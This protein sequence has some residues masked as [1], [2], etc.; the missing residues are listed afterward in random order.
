MTR[1]TILRKTLYTA[2]IGALAGGALPMHA[3]AQERGAAPVQAPAPVRFDIPAQPMPAALQAFSDQSGMQLLYRAEAVGSMMSPAVKGTLDRREALQQMLAGTGLEV[4]YSNGDVATV[5]PRTVA[6]TRENGGAAQ[7]DRGASLDGQNDLEDDRRQAP[8]TPGRRNVVIGEV[9]VTGTRI[10]GGETP[11]PVITIGAENIR[12]EG[13]TDLGEVIRSVPQNF[14]GGQNPG[15]AAGA[16]TGAAGLAN[17]N[18][19]GG[20]S[21]NLRGLGPDATLTLLNGRRMAYGGFTQT[22]DISAIPVEAVDRV[23]IVAD[24]SSAIYGSDAVGGVG[25][26]ILKRDFEGLSLGARY[27]AASDGGMVTNEYNATAG[28]NWLGGGLLATYKYSS[29][30]PIYAANRDYTDHL[31]EPTTIYPGSHVRSGLVSAYQA[32]GQLAELRIDALR[33]ERDQRF[34]YWHT[35][36]AHF[37]S[38]ILPETTTSLVAPSVEIALPNDWTLSIGGA[39]GKD[40]HIWRMFDVSTSSAQLTS[41]L[42]EC[43]CNETR[44]YELG[45]EGPLF[46]L[47]G[48]DARLAVGAGHRANDYWQFNYVTDVLAVEGDE[49]SRFAYAELHLPLSGPANPTSGL[50]RLAL[51]AAVRGEDYDT[52]GSV[53]TPKLGLVYGP[54]ADVTMKAS[55]GRSFKAP[56]LYQRYSINRA[57]LVPPVSYGGVGYPADAMLLT[58][59]SG[60]RDLD[61]ERARTWAMS[62]A[63]HPRSVPG[64]EAELTWF[65]IDYTDRV[66]QPITNYGAAL[67]T[68]AYAQF[69][70]FSPSTERLAEV[71]ADADEFHLFQG[72]P[73]VP[74]NVVAIMD[75]RYVN[76]SRQ[77]I[78]GLDLTGSYRVDLGA[79][80]LTIR[81]SAS[82]LDSTQQNSSEQP[83]YDVAG[84]LYNP[85]KLQAR[86]GG[87][88]TQG[89]FT[90]SLFANYTSGVNNTARDEKTDSFTTFD[91]AVRHAVSRSDSA[92]PGWEIAFSAHNLLNRK[93]PFH[94]VPVGNPYWAPYDST[95][96]SAIGRFLSL[97]VAVRW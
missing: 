50:H 39:W 24:G 11:S 67:S 72:I 90:A 37:Y 84:T 96:Y 91:A 2:I 69:I 61:P 15:V 71:I 68:P 49:S 3:S 30:K 58:L 20:S 93:P 92:W 7:S 78:K 87:V 46:R 48:G 86:T 31:L 41:R 80:R 51:T 82:W 26:V 66:V 34:D 42:N 62:F 5:R 79:G 33:T 76:V 32:I 43:W 44:S 47:P 53:V 12:E 52:F 60:N 10:R 18:I 89:Q 94:N 56:T 75:A 35:N 85:A 19:T 28:A 54:S 55:W 45:G 81:G 8:P 83:W 97:S 70:E 59:S 16:A 40:E 1:A 4:V 38:R 64:L 17:Q 21:L 36:I 77:R 63:L 57:V 9:V 22:V 6:P 13:F 95:N 25:N 27:G 14:N 73:Y 65:G 88:W 29:V 74:E 23:E